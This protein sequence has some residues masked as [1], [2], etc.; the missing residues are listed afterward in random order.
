[1][2]NR[3]ENVLSSDQEV[4]DEPNDAAR[5]LELEYEMELLDNISTNHSDTEGISL[6]LRALIDDKNLRIATLEYTV[7]EFEDFLKENPDIKDLHDLKCLVNHRE[8]RIQQLEDWIEINSDVRIEK[9]RIMELEQMLTSL[10]NYVKSHNVDTL[11]LKL[12][13]RENRIAQ[14]EKIVERAKEK[15]EKELESSEEATIRMMLLEKEQ[16][17]NDKDSKIVAYKAQALECHSQMTRMRKEM[18]QLEKELDQYE[19]QDFD[20]LKQEIRVRDERVVL[21]EDQIDSLE[22]ALSDRI[23]SKQIEELVDIIKNQEEKANQLENDLRTE[24][25]RKEQLAEALRGNVVIASDAENNFKQVE[26]AKKNAIE[27]VSNALN[28]CSYSYSL[29]EKK[30]KSN[31]FTGW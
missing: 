29:Y 22:R 5:V 27:R 18:A 25:Q 10:E 13:D 16:Q 9:T 12:Q 15:S 6:K 14:L 24:R 21:L 8:R 19:A 4:N 7:A 30:I 28:L 2:K 31:F 20:V 3:L 17:L 23:D 1:M 11:N 26:F